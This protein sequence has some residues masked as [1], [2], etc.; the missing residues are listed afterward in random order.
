MARNFGSNDGTSGDWVARARRARE[1]GDAALSESE[2]A[3][4]SRLRKENTYQTSQFTGE[5]LARR[6]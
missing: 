3:A 4:L 5:S 2:G 6:L 1:S